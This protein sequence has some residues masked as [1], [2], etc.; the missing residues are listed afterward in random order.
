MKAD[1]DITTTDGSQAQAEQLTTP[2]GVSIP[3]AATADMHT[4]HQEMPGE[5]PYTRGIF[6]DG[7]RGRLWT[8]REYSGFGTAEES[9]QRYRFLLEQGQTGLSVAFDL[10]TQCGYD[11][12]DPIARPEIGK[13]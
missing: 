12:T 3:L 10:P 11:P 1:P 6:A 4:N 8:M 7:Y 2:S 13:V 9:N 5:Y